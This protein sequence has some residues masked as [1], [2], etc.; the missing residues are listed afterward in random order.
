MVIAAKVFIIFLCGYEFLFFELAMNQHIQEKIREEIE[1][2]Y[3]TQ[4]RKMSS[5][6]DKE[7]YLYG[8]GYSR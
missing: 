8:Y 2:V 5:G 4:D 3:G 7:F 1:Q 6:N